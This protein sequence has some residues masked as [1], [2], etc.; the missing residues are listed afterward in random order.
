VIE[1][2][3]ETTDPAS[4]TWTG[5][6]NTSG[7]ICAIVGDGALNTETTYTIRVIVTDANGYS[8]AFGTL[9]STK[10]VIDFMTGGK[11]AAF[12]KSAELEGVLDIGFK[13]RFFGGILYPVLDPETDLNDIKT[14]NTYIGANVADYAYV[15][16]PVS[17]GTFTLIVESGG[18]EGQVRQTYI[19]CSKYKPER[20]VRFYYQEAWGEWFWAGTEEYVL[21]EN[22]N[23]SADTITLNASVANY[24]YIEIYYTDNNNK[25]QGYT[26]IWNANNK[27]AHLQLQEAG[28]NPYF[29]QT[30]YSIVGTSITP[31]VATASYV[32]V[33]TAGAVTTSIGTNYIKIV[34]VI[35]RA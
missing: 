9:S 14:P 30:A 6:P 28:S 2:E 33:S 1:W 19:S 7:H 22:S 18:A 17:S 24:R 8:Y 21:Y 13:T 16:C 26:K 20:Y 10:F 34:R 27:V 3:S 31:E 4:M 32:R 11:G 23:G 35:G 25:G 15:N 29:R 5:S 12:N